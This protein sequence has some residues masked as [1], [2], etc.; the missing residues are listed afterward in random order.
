MH[1]RHGTVAHMAQLGGFDLKIIMALIWSFGLTE[2]HC[3]H[4]HHGHD[5]IIVIII[6]VTIVIII[7][8]TMVTMVTS[9]DINVV[10]PIIILNFIM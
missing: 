10:I 8:I 6:M 2:K 3:Y 4:G 9:A 5:H 1:W 7:V